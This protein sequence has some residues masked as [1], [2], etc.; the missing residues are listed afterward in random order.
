ML[1]LFFRKVVADAE[2]TSKRWPTTVK[3]PVNQFFLP[4]QQGQIAADVFDLTRQLGAGLI[5]AALLVASHFGSV[6]FIDFQPLMLVPQTP[7][8]DCFYSD[9]LLRMR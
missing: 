7:M 1:P 8:Y 5:Y 6:Q 2:Q 4:G 3:T 9:T